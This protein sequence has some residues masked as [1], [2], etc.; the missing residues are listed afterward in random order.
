M[1]NA[2]LLNRVLNIPMASNAIEIPRIYDV[3]RST[4][5]MH[6]VTVPSGVAEA[7][8]LTDMSPSFGKCQLKLSKIGGR[9]RV[10]NEMMQDSP[11]AMSMLLPR[12]FSEAI[13]FELINQL[14]NGTGVGQMLG[15][16]NAPATIQVA[17][18]DGQAADSIEWQNVIKMWS[19]LM[20]SAKQNAVW[21]A[22]PD[23]E[24]WL[25]SMTIN[26][27]TG[28]APLMVVNAS[29]TQPATLFG[30]PLFFVEQ[31]PALGNVGDILVFNPHAYCIGRKPNDMIRIDISEHARFE[32]DQTVFR[33]I[34]RCDGQPL[35]SAPIT[36]KNGGATL[37]HFVTLAERAE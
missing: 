5:G 26:V 9:C 8:A 16:L 17:K 34:A 25:R 10:S 6:G 35:Q 21:L 15:I 30:R 13:S 27:G 7:S 22:S 2:H 1:A 12:I 3:N 33:A 29:E 37:S 36:P 24:V 11:L 23:V 32:N 31:C 28:G 4:T 18:E 20:P 14:I 19:R